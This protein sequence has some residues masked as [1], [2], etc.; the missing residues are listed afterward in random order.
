MEKAFFENNENFYR[1]VFDLEVGSH[2][3]FPR[4]FSIKQDF[5]GKGTSLSHVSSAG[6]DT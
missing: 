3:Y 6:R 5:G 4:A 1:E 2:L